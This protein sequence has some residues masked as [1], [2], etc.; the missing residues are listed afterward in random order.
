MNIKIYVI[1]QKVA[2]QHVTYSSSI[3]VRVTEC[4]E[5]EDE[6]MI[7]QYYHSEFLYDH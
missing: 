5:H 6:L 7:A 4:G 3:P 2:S 1:A